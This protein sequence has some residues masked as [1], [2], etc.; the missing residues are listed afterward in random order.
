LKSSVSRCFGKS[1]CKPPSVH[2][3]TAMNKKSI[4]RMNA[5]GGGLAPYKTA[6]EGEG[7]Y[8]TNAGG[9]RQATRV[10]QGSRSGLKSGES[11]E[12]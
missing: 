11:E 4:H 8:H 10:Q 2:L 12:A 7:L 9:G 6:M 5:G 1:A 3:K